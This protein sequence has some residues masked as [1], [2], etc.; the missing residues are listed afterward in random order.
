MLAEY[1]FDVGRRRIV[2]L[3]NILHKLVKVINHCIG[4]DC[5]LVLKPFGKGACFRIVGEY[6]HIIRFAMRRNLVALCAE[7]FAR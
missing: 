1:R 4:D 6:R 7:A 2:K 5:V 3:L